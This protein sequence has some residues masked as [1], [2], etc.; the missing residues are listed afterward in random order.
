MNW[1]I[2]SVLCN[3]PIWVNGFAYIHRVMQR[4]PL[5]SLE[6]FHYLSK[7]HTSQQAFPSHPPPHPWEIINLLSVS[8]DLLVLDIPMNQIEDCWPVLSFYPTD[9]LGQWGKMAKGR[10]SPLPT[11]L[12]VSWSSADHPPSPTLLLEI[13]TLLLQRSSSPCRFIFDS[14]PPP[15]QI[16]FS[17]IRITVLPSSVASVFSYFFIMIPKPL[18]TQLK[19]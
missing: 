13:S 19:L 4:S 9:T 3:S 8:I 11:S 6:N 2:I 15:L 10:V 18:R 16:L 5:S 17:E 1:D 12:A 14:P 7:P